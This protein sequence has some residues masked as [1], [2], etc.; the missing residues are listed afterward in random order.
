MFKIYYLAYGSNLNL[1]EMKRRCPDAKA[2]G[3]TILENY[4]LVYKGSKGYAYLTIEES[5]GD[6]IPLGIFELAKSDL[7]SLDNYEG[8]P[9]FYD[10]FILDVNVN[11]KRKNAYIYVMNQGFDYCLPSDEYQKRCYEGY[12]DFNFDTKPLDKAL[13]DTNELSKSRRKLL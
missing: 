8:Y 12:K 1:S 2:I 11:G 4:R 3:S 9:G 6:K 5:P 10:R 13:E 7:N